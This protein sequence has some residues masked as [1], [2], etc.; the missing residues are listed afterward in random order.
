M[1]HIITIFIPS[2]NAGG[3]EKVTVNL[4]NGLLRYCKYIDIITMNSDGPNRSIIDKRIHLFDMHI[5]N[6]K[7]SML[8]LRKYINDRKPLVFISV[9][10]YANIASLIATFGMYDKP[11]QYLISHQTISSNPNNKSSLTSI[12]LLYLLPILYPWSTGI[13]SVSKGSALDLSFQTGIK[14]NRIK[15]LPNPVVTDDML[16][17][18]KLPVYHNWIINKQYPVLL[19]VG[20]LIS[21]KCHDILIKAFAIVSKYRKAKLLIL[22]D[23]PEKNALIKLA[24]DLNVYNNI[25]FL[26]Y[27]SNPYNYMA[28]TD[29]FILSSKS[30]ALPTVLIEALACGSSIVSTDCKYGPREILSYGKYGYLVPIND[31]YSLAKSILLVLSKPHSKAPKESWSKYYIHNASKEFFDSVIKPHISY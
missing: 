26:G 7:Y 9:L 17:M 3:G 10:D 4:A 25:Q 19:S 24:R 13:I 8:P 15:I 11:H 14:L 23:G 16:N 30:E 27:V 29:A 1:K 18:S 31:P 20:S 5:D 21:L 28:A 6:M 22:G 2:L 12:F